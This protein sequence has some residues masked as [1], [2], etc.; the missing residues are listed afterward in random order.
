MD[1]NLLVSK[2]LAQSKEHVHDFD[3]FLLSSRMLTEERGH[4]LNK[5]RDFSCVQQSTRSFRSFKRSKA[6]RYAVHDVNDKEEII[7]SGME[8]SMWV[9]KRMIMANIGDQRVAMQC[10]QRG[11]KATQRL[12]GDE[13][14]LNDSSFTL[15]ASFHIPSA[16]VHTVFQPITVSQLIIHLH[17]QCA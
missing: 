11:L 3:A 17:G 7:S 5:K 14:L 15:L 16:Q 1:N 4:G 6:Q 8:A 9:S 13:A 10:R 2:Y 12:F